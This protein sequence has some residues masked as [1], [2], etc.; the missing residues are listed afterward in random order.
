LIRVK[1]NASCETYCASDGFYVL[2]VAPEEI[3]KLKQ[4]YIDIVNE[5]AVLAD[6]YDTLMKR[7][8]SMKESLGPK[9]QAERV[10]FVVVM[11]VRDKLIVIGRVGP[12]AE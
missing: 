1:D 4:D 12:S 3:Q 10:E 6:K 9:L 5:K 2:D 8:S 7:L 11:T